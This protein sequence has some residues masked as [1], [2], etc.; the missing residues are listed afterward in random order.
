MV[1]MN[2]LEFVK[3]MSIL[4]QNCKISFQTYSFKIFSH[5]DFKILVS[6]VQDVREATHR[7][8]ALYI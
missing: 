5:L 4:V 6:C 3:E 1:K 2:H 8:L 7:H